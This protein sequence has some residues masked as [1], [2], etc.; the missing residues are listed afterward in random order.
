MPRKRAQ[1]LEAG[2]LL[3]LRQ[4]RDITPSGVFPLAEDADVVLS[5]RWPP[6]LLPPLLCFTK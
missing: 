4:L 6:L 5:L 3:A 1:P 2:F